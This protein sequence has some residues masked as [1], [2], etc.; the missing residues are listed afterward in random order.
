MAVAFC[1]TDKAVCSDQAC[2]QGL[3]F[4]KLMV[5]GGTDC[6]MGNAEQFSNLLLIVDC[7]PDSGLGTS[8]QAALLSVG[9]TAV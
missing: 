3:A 1:V 4:E 8:S 9:L 6:I 7:V 5:P 2:S